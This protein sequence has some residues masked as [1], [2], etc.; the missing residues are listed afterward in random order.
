MKY[1]IEQSKEDL[2]SHSGLALVGAL[3]AKTKLNQRL[4]QVL[5]V[6]NP[7]PLITNGDVAKSYIGLLCQGKNDFDHIEPFRKDRFFSQ[8]LGIKTVPSSP[9]M[10]QRLDMAGSE[11]KH[12]WNSILLEESARLLKNCGV[13]ITPCNG[14]HIPLDIDVSPFDNS[15]TKKEW[16]ELLGLYPEFKFNRAFGFGS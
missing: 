5:F 12:Q 14:T 13:A 3:I 6:N 7:T 1:L 16:V 15:K 11:E 4:N 2:T 10:R 8:S 9:T